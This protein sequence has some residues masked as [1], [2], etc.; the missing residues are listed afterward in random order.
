[1]I[2]HTRIATGFDVELLLGGNYF[3][4]IFQGAYDAGFISTNMKTE[5]KQIETG[6]PAVQ[7]SEHYLIEIAKPSSL[8]ILTDEPEADMEITIPIT[9]TKMVTENGVLTPGEP[10]S[11]AITIRLDIAF[12][13]T[14]LIIAYHSLGDITQIF[15]EALVGAEGVAVIDD[16]LTEKLNQ[17]FPLNLVADGVEMAPPLKIRGSGGFQSAYGFYLNLTDIKI[18]P[19]SGPSENTFIGRGN[20]NAAA[21]FL[22]TD[23]DIA[24]GLAPATFNRLANH[25]WHTELTVIAEDGTVSHPVMDEGEVVGQYKS[26]TIEPIKEGVIEVTIK[27]R[28]FLTAWPDATV[29][30]VFHLQS[31]VEDHNLRFNLDLVKFNVNTG[32][33]GDLLAY[34]LGGG[35]GVILL[36]IFEFAAQRRNQGD[37]ES[38]GKKANV[39]AMFSTIPRSLHLFDDTRDPLFVGEYYVVNQFSEAQIDEA[40]MSFVGQAAIA[41][42]NRPLPVQLVGRQRGS[43]EGSWNGLRSLTYRLNNSG[44]EITLTIPEVM[45]RVARQQLQ[46]HLRLNLTHIRRRKTVV[47]EMLFDTGVDFLVSEMA[48]LQINTIAGVH[49]YQFIRPRNANPYFRARADKDHENNLELLPKF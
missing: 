17:Q 47:K 23:K 16:L 38:E 20:V 27:S 13:S 31:R 15:L 9:A 45:T 8:T 2:D 42:A 48:N 34:L 6:N 37:A 7:R 1:M 49:G 46:S 10:I 3:L 41:T 44:Q 29:T 43:G 21:S 33:L 28:I 35:L 4:T 36:E 14:E 19:Q 18:A 11:T 32:L 40:G 39:A 25:L 30:A 22:P 26:I 12:T 5:E 24:I